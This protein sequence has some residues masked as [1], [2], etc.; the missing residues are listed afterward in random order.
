MSL[1]FITNHHTCSLSS[2]RRRNSAGSSSSEIPSSFS[3][4][5]SIE[6]LFDGGVGDSLRPA[7]IYFH[8]KYEFDVYHTTKTK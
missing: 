8:K 2:R 1:F 7:K 3:L 4:G 5:A 6:S